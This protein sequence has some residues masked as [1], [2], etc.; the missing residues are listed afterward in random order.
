M[1]NK[2]KKSIL[3]TIGTFYFLVSVGLIVYLFLIQNSTQKEFDVQLSNIKEKRD[4]LKKR[5]NF[6]QDFLVIDN[7]YI[8]G[9][10]EKAVHAYEEITSHKLKTPFEQ[11]L[12][13]LRLNRI[14]EILNNIDT[15][16]ADIEAYRFSLNAAR[17]EIELIKNE[18]DS[19][20]SKELA[21][22]EGLNS[23][24]ATLREDITEKNIELTK[25]EKVQVISFRNEKGNLIHYLGEVK[26]GMANGGGVGIW[27]TGGLYKGNWKDNQ[28]H[29]EGVYTWKDGH[30]YEGAFV[31]GVREGQ[32]TYYWSSGE[33]HEGEWKNN[34][35][36]GEGTLYDRDNNVQF[37]GLW[38]DD[39]IKK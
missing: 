12:I 29:G 28:R 4:S 24:I 6:L 23:T 13:D 39:K 33:K 30:K 8:L 14:N 9:Q 26:N 35:R 7:N 34:Q 2:Q 15:L 18:K 38:V 5:E 37:K 11:D 27:D 1:K 19:L 3:Y 21:E 20:L 10:Y 32:G 17:E 25:K 31:E 36:N 16:S 22:K